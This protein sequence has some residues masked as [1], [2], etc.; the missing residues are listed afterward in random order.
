M[1]LF[2]TFGTEVYPSSKYCFDVVVVALEVTNF[3]NKIST[4]CVAFNA[5]SLF[6][7]F[8]T[9]VK[10]IGDVVGNPILTYTVPL[11]FAPGP[12]VTLLTV[13]DFRE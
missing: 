5:I 7:D 4:D 9:P 12:N 2:K 1:L 13:A 3:L 8:V 10:V 6:Y 11:T